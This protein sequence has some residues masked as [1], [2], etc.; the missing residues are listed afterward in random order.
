M[1]VPRNPN[2]LITHPE[3]AAQAD[4]WDPSTV[5]RGSDRKLQWKCPVG[6]TWNATVSSRTSLNLGCPIC[7]GQRV[8]AGFNDLATT[9]PNLVPLIV[10]GDPKAVSRGSRVKFTWRCDLGHTFDSSVSNVIHGKWCPYCAG[11]KVLK[12]FNDFATKYP[13]LAAEADGWDPATKT[14]GTGEKLRWRCQRGH[15]YLAGPNSRGQGRGCPYCANRLLLPGFNDLLTTHPFM[16]AEADGWDPTCV[17]MGTTKRLPWK[18]ALGHHWSVSHASRVSRNSGCPTCAGLIVKKGFNDLA[19]KFPEVAAEA[20]GWDPST[21]APVTAKKM[22]WKCPEGH[23]WTAKVSSRTNMGAGC[24]T[25]SKAGFDPNE[26]GWLYFMSH[27]QWDMYQIGITNFPDKRL[28]THKRLGWNVEEVRGPMDGHLTRD[29]ETGM[30]RILRRN[31]A[32][33]ANK[34]GGAIFDGWTESWLMNGSPVCSL[35]ELLRLLYEES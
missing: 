22:K 6:H 33:F 3:L 16:A 2:L 32:T 19:T 23:K 1:G 18:C 28:T 9:H 4:G 10:R 25:C 29:L 15:Q 7:S 35:D 20:D 13:E 24:P 12:G 31:N 34:A 30:L 5:S 27:D 21:V 11:Q 26:E 17:L 14:F 8:L